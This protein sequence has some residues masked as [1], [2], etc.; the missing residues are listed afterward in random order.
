MGGLMRWTHESPLH[1]ILQLRFLIGVSKAHATRLTRLSLDRTIAGAGVGVVGPV[2]GDGLAEHE[3]A[4][5]RAALF[6]L[7]VCS[8]KSSRAA[9]AATRLHIAYALFTIMRA[10]LT[11]L[12]T[13]MGAVR[14]RV[15]L[16]A[17]AAT[18]FQTRDGYQRTR[19]TKHTATYVLQ[20]LFKQI[21]DGPPAQCSSSRSRITFNV[22]SARSQSTV[23][24]TNDCWLSPLQRFLKRSLKLILA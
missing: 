3:L 19:A 20:P 18:D 15:C 8:P 4:E 10:L 7:A 9:W 5:Q 6:V 13:D 11:A 14:V 2:G 12:F 23:S 17:Q 16:I 22:T 24:R 1:Q 21:Y